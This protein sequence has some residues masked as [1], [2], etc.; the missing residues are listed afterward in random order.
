[1]QNVADVGVGADPCVRP[2]GEDT[3]VC[4]LQE[5]ESLWIHQAKGDLGRKGVPKQELGNE[6]EIR[7]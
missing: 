5:R 3:R 1:V 7:T 6:D 2:L 4:L